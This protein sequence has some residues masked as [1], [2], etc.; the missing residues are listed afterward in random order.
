MEPLKRSLEKSYVLW[1]KAEKLIMDGTCLYSKMPIINVKGVTPAYIQRASGSHIF[2]IDGNE[3][4]DFS[5][6]LG[7]IILGYGYPR[8]KNA[9]IKQLDDGSI[10]SMPHPL[11]VEVAE[12]LVKHVPSA[13]MVRFLKT[14]AEATSAAVR[15]A[16]AYTGREKIIRGEYHGWHDWG[17]ANTEKNVGI[18]KCLKDLVFYGHYNNFDEFKRFFEE[19]PDQIAAIITEPIELEEPKDNFLH[20][21]KK[22]A[23]DNGALLIFDEVVTGFRFDLGGAQKYFGVIPDITAF[24]KAIANGMPLSAVAASTEI[25]NSVKDKIFISSTFG[26]ETLSLAASKAM[27]SEMEEKPV[28]KRI[29]EIGKKIK[30]ESE[31]IIKENDIENY[32]KCIGL[33]PRL[34]FDFKKDGKLWLELKTLFVQEVIKRGVFLGWNIFPSFSHTDDDVEKTLEVISDA[35]NICKKAIENNNVKDMLEGE[36]LQTVI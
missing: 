29:W 5:N 24:G 17:I 1:S 21:I 16:R 22:L 10:F 31:R 32:V 4:I 15:I 34:A 11:E 20:K 12:L 14:G 28:N 27:I 9:I 18:P 19:N 26:G 3:Y 7:P 13:E 25:I 2:D 23:H 8:V 30:E 33:P 36:V 35:V 6:A